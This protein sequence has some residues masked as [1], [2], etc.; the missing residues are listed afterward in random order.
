MDVVKQRA[1]QP[2]G[3]TLGVILVVWIAPAN[4]TGA[5]PQVEMT[6]L[7]GEDLQA[8]TTTQARFDLQLP[9]RRGALFWP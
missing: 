4:A 7:V 1:H 3:V 5:I 8:K 2:E 9:G 6:K